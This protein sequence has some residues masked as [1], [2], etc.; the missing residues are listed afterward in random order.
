MAAQGA[1][2]YRPEDILKSPYVLGFAGL[3]NKSSYHESD[4]E[5]GVLNKLQSFFA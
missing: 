2:P 4:L 3:D 5:A 1:M